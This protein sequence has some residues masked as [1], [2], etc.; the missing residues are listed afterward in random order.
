MPGVG[1]LEQIA[2]KTKKHQWFNHINEVCCIFAD[3]SR[4]LNGILW[5]MEKNCLVI[6]SLETRDVCHFMFVVYTSHFWAT[7]CLTSESMWAKHT[8]LVDN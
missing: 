8:S 3:L 4:C 5:D 1:N 6:P 2:K 7:T